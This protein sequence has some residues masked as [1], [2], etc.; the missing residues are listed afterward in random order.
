MPALAVE[1]RYPSNPLDR[2]E[3]LAEAN[4]WNVERQNDDEVSM[5]IE[6][7]WG[8]LQLSLNWRQDIEGLHLAACYDFKVGPSRRE[9]VGRLLGLINEQLYLGHFDLWRHDGTVVFRNGLTLAGGAEAN[10]AQCEALI[11]LAIDA[12][13]RYYPAFQFV[14]WAGKPA[15]DAITASL[16]ETVGEA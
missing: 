12:C 10:E 13:E 8:T 9:E 3:E 4:D 11:S 1:E 14:I 7:S 15:E 2:V 16:L 5:A 6:A